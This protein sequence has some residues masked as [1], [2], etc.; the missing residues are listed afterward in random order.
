MKEYLYKGFK[1][2]YQIIVSDPEKNRFKAHGYVTYL[3]HGH[4]ALPQAKFHTESDSAE[5][6]ERAIKKLLEHYINF[7]RK[8]FHQMQ[9]ETIS[10]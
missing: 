6:A 2:S 9:N 1:I 5:H 3:P 10:S 8:N 7:E 4:H